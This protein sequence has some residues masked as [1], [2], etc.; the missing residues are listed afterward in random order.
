MK[1]M[2]LVIALLGGLWSSNAMCLGVPPSDRAKAEFDAVQ[3]TLYEGA[4]ALARNDADALEHY[5]AAEWLSV[6]PFNVGLVSGVGFT[7]TR[8]GDLKYESI[9]VTEPVTRVYGT[10]AVSTSRILVKGTLKG[11]DISGAYRVSTML[12][13]KSGRWQIIGL[14][15]S[16]AAPA[17]SSK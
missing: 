5:Y 14:I 3:Q 15:S 12:V 6:T 9:Q 13:K 11:R 8:N 17:P 4:D 10:A 1:S 16:L 2:I 7:A